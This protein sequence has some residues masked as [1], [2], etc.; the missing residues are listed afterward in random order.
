[1]YMYIV[2]CQADDV[3]YVEDISAWFSSYST[4]TG[5]SLIFVDLDTG[6]RDKRA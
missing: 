5:S 2:G 1:M 3:R 4:P 6:T